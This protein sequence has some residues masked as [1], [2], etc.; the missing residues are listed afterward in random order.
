MDIY[1][2]AQHSTQRPLPAIVF[3][4][5]GGWVGGS[6]AHFKSQAE[7]LAKRGIIAIT[8]EYRIASKHQT[9]P[10]IAIEDA[11]SAM[12]WIASHADS[13]GVDTS[14]IAVAGGSAGG[15]LALCTA[16]IDTFDDP[17]YQSQEPL[18]PS[19]LVLFNP[20]VNTSKMGYGAEKL[21]ADTLKASP[22]HHIQPDMPPTL[23]FHGTADQTVPY[24][25]ITDFDKKMKEMDNFC[26]VVPFQGRGHGFFNK[27]RGNDLDYLKTL[28]KTDRFLRLLGYL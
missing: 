26:Q 19:A 14:R 2:P 1:Y 22:Y 24:Q 10:Q 6:K 5:G 25:N 11:R 9:P 15:H 16:L 18:M 17:I 21:G 23:I 28:M 3:Y 27:G 12:Y 8:P 7:Y 13:L 20:V 4:F